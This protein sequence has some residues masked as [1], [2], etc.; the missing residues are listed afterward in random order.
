[1]TSSR[2]SIGIGSNDAANVT[3]I[4]V[5]AGAGFVAGVQKLVAPPAPKNA[6]KAPSAMP[7]DLARSMFTTPL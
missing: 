3:A 6:K 1:M 7:L 2:P 4:R 5:G